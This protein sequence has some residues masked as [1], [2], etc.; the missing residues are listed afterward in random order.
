MAVGLRAAQ[1]KIVSSRL[2]VAM[3]EREEKVATFSRGEASRWNDWFPW[4]LG[5]VALKR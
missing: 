4:M 5:R 1:S 3:P 2:K